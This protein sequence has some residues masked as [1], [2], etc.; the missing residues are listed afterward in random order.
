MVPSAI[1]LE[2]RT[3]GG[4]VLS[5]L[6]EGTPRGVESRTAATVALLGAAA[7]A[8]VDVPE[9]WG[10]YPW[11]AG[12]TGLKLTFALSGLAPVLSAVGA[13]AERSEVVPALRG[14][15]GAGVLYA[16]LPPEAA[17]AT[18]ADVVQRLR[19]V[20]AAYGGAAVV[21]DAPPEVKTVVDTWGPV[22]ALELMRR[23]KDQ[24]DP[25]HRLAPGRFVGGI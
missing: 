12:G 13:C 10:R 5:V 1:E 24:F 14:S 19:A 9:Q 22:T 7:R 8:D 16:A 11:V 18:V 21:L 2:S 20:C 25:E 23:V 4:G 17:P 15:A 6:L 3:R